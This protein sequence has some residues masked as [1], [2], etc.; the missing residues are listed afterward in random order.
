[1]CGERKV[2]RIWMAFTIIPNMLNYI[3]H[4]VCIQSDLQLVSVSLVGTLTS[5]H[6]ELEVK[7]VPIP[8]QAKQ[9]QGVKQQ[10]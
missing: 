5:G 6:E 10:L 8:V 4:Y 2:I 3:L 7:Y 9:H 1:M